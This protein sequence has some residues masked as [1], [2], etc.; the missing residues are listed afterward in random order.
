[1]PGPS[2]VQ[3]WCVEGVSGLHR[4][5]DMARLVRACRE[6]DQ[7][8]SEASH[9][10]RQARTVRTSFMAVRGPDRYDTAMFWASGGDEWRW[11]GVLLLNSREPKGYSQKLGPIRYVSQGSSPSMGR[12]GMAAV[13]ALPAVPSPL[14]AM[15]RLADGEIRTAAD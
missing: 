13:A 2:V 6:D 5:H 9:R 11:Q 1:L 12:Q 10:C 14:T 7:F 8:V 15:P 4:C 3:I